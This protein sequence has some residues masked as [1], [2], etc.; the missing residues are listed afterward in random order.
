MSNDYRDNSRE[1]LIDELISLRARTLQLESDQASRES[2]LE[3]LEVSKRRYEQ[4]VQNV[5]TIILC[6]LPDGTITF[7]NNYA[8]QFFGYNK[9]ELIG[10]KSQILV[11]EI[12]TGGR[13]LKP[14][15]GKILHDP[16]AFPTHENENICRDGRRVWISWSNRSIRNKQGNVI[17]TFSV[18]TDITDRKKAQQQVLQEQEMLRALLESQEKDRKLVAFEI[19]DGL[20]QLIT[21]A[22]MQFQACDNDDPNAREL[23]GQP[24]KMG[25]EMLDQSL[26]ETR[27]LI[28]GLRPPILDEE[29]VVAAIDH[30]IK[31]LPEEAGRK[32]DFYHQVSFDRLEPTTENC[33]FRIV[34][35]SLTNAIRYSKAEQIHVSL[36]EQSGMISLS[37]T[38]NGLGFEPSEV[39]EKHFGLKGIR[40]RALLFGG[41]A[42]IKSAPGRGTE[43]RATLPS[44]P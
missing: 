41:N 5:N 40:E 38:D 44:S 39:E 11:P 14:R 43:I 10:Q 3:K 33:I 29:G 16:E 35:E 37:I 23:L 24:F 19:H 12:E 22:K 2:N 7:A 42:T 4:I 1:E 26:S 34:Q 36:V 28:G 9:E 8:C 17:D 30:L 25:L 13:K 18:G 32:V 31:T 21:A 15:L 6:Q 27:R 20:A